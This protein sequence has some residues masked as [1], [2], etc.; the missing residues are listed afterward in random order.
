MGSPWGS[1]KAMW[2]QTH[3]PSFPPEPL[4]SSLFLSHGTPPSQRLYKLFFLTVE[5]MRWR[6]RHLVNSAPK[7]AA[8]TALLSGKTELT[9]RVRG[10]A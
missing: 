6:D 7:K 8:S 4:P 2:P 10:V 3:C 1:R 5:V 9:A